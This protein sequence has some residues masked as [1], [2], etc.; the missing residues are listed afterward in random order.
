MEKR[1]VSVLVV[2][3]YTHLPQG[4][5]STKFPPLT[6]TALGPL[7]Q[8]G[9]VA[10]NPKGGPLTFSKEWNARE[11]CSFFQKHLP[12][13]FQY[14]AE[15][16]G[17][18]ER[19]V[20][21]S[22]SSLPY[23]TLSKLRSVYSI[24]LVPSANTVLNGKFYQ[25]HAS[26]LRGSSYK[27]RYIILGQRPRVLIPVPYCLLLYALLVSKKPIPQ[28][29]LEDWG[30][31][32]L[33]GWR[34]DLRVKALAISEVADEE[35][36][37]GPSKKRKKAKKGLR[38]TWTHQTGTDHRKVRAEAKDEVTSDSTPKRHLKRKRHNSASG[39]EGTFNA[40]PTCN[41]S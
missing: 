15:S 26:G 18:D 9:L 22:E 32:P 35:M 17:Y 5:E 25:T 41:N 19:K 31:K 23:R 38:I 28:H 6:L 34:K 8:Q 21:N 7:E 24:V 2:Y 36:V 37:R 10:R 11:M 40:L 20:T 33:L 16:Q 29:V 30:R 1:S 3:T 13:P 4:V 14:F 39:S 27:Q 12:R